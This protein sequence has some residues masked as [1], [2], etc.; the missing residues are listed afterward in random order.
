MSG[1]R[2]Q[3]ITFYSF[4][5]GVGRSMAVANVA[6][7]L[8]QHGKK[9]LV[10]DFDFEA[11]G[12]HRYFLR[13]ATSEHK[14][15]IERFEPSRPRRGVID[16][17]K[18]LRK[19]LRERLP[20]EIYDP[21]D[22][23]SR[24]ALQVIVRELLRSK[25]Y[26][27]RVHLQNPNNKKKGTAALDFI[28]AGRFDPQYVKRVQG[29]DWKRFYGDYAEVFPVLADELA[30]HYDYVL[31]DSRTGFTDIGS[32]CTMVL[33]DKLVLVF[34]PNEQSLAGAVEVGEEA[35]RQRAALADRKPLPVFPLLSRLEDSEEILKRKWVKRATESFEA[36]CKDVYNLKECDLEAYFD[37]ARV[38]HRAYYAYGERIA[39]EEEKEIVAGSL[40]HGFKVFADCLEYE[41]P[42]EVR[43]APRPD[44]DME[45][46]LLEKLGDEGALRE[47]IKRRPEDPRIRIQY[48][49]LLRIQGRPSEAIDVYNGV[50]DRFSGAKSPK[51]VAHVAHA[52]F[53]KGICFGEL[54][55][56]DQALAAYDDVVRWFGDA[57]TLPLRVW[58]V[59]ALRLKASSLN[60]SKRSQEAVT[61]Y[62]ELLRRFSEA[63][64]PILQEYVARAL[65]SKGL[66]LC[67]LERL[68]EAVGVYDDVVRRFGEAAELP[69]REVVARTLVNKGVALDNLKRPEEAVGV[70][71]EVLRRFGEAAELSLLEVVARALNGI[72]FIRLC[73]AKRIWLAGDH[74]TAIKVLQEARAQITAARERDPR[75]PICLGNAGY[76][77]FLLGRREEARALLAEA[78]QRGGEE[79]R[80]DELADADIHTLP[81]DEEFRALVRSL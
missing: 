5:G 81:E 31:L 71:D 62:D 33:P 60:D 66:A 53:M 8:A 64:E 32:I 68:E 22:L 24:Q 36:L 9:V 19:R 27:Y 47:M 16:F 63:T 35:V 37:L 72:A 55:Q 14:S 49:D 2:G 78:I 51:V 42:Y 50:I 44:A 34:T 39:A 18:A 70:Y 73:D 12:L 25:S 30:K 67:D 3:I 38:P 11:P 48:A 20:P 26:R 58:V 52:T 59:L 80:K 75:N 43:P 76:I 28:A 10:L 46:A 17:F 23:T 69:L 15:K 65:V 21:E 29:F 54:E 13:P 41:K 61:V 45:N 79:L 4:K 7:I 6:T 74:E 56:R 77:A 40:A 57:T 1:R